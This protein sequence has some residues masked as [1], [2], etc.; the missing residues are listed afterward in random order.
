MSEYQYYEFAAIDRP[1]TRTE[2]A[3]LRAVSTRA[4]ITPGG[5]TNHYEWGDLKA[6]PAE[7]MRRYFDAFVYSANWCSCH[8]SLRLPKAVFRKGELD[9]FARSA[10]LSFESSDSHWIVSWTLEESEDYDRFT[11]D[12]GSGWMR[13]LIPLRDELMRGDLRPLYLGWL[14]AGDALHDDML[15]PEVP[16]GLA[17]LSPAQQALVEFLEIDPDLLV[18]ASMSSAAATSPHDETLQISTWLDTWQTADMQDVLKTIALGRGQEAERQVKSHYA[19]WLKAQRPASS[20]AARRQVAELQ[21]LAQSAAATRRAR[22]AQ[23]HAK[24]EEERRQK[25]EGELRRIMDSPDKYWKA[26]SEQAYRGSAS[27]Y[28]KTVSLLKVLAEGYALVV[29]PDAFDRQL[30]RFLV[31]HAKRAA[32]LRRL[33]EAGL[34]LG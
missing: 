18:A 26:A 5:F 17:D 12:D 9:A 33:A 7:W 23:A 31:P 14:A 16:C 32:L 8:V 1:L 13:R 6:D 4:D 25:R 3:E 27:G 2:M 28:E 11:E 22:E 30:R 21:E 19:A 29:G 24:R 20:G 34:W 10:A 15:E